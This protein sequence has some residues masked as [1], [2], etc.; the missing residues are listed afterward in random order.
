MFFVVLCCLFVSTM[1][2][3]KVVDVRIGTGPATTAAAPATATSA[4]TPI[5]YRA[6][7]GADSKQRMDEFFALIDKNCTPIAASFAQKIDQWIDSKD[8][9]KYQK[10]FTAICDVLVHPLQGIVRLF[11][12]SLR[13]AAVQRKKPLRVARIDFRR[14]SD[15]ARLFMGRVPGGLP[16]DLNLPVKFLTVA[17]VPDYL[18]V[19]SKSAMDECIAMLSKDGTFAIWQCFHKQAFTKWDAFMLPSQTASTPTEE[20]VRMCTHCRATDKPTTWCKCMRVAY[21]S[22]T[23]R[24]ACAEEHNARCVPVDEGKV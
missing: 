15:L 4:N 13:E 19:G 6:T 10:Q 16:F 11:G 17:E 18:P 2:R 7:D 23:C 20:V 5:S 8:D 9:A 14:V 1:L 3:F 12:Q 24:D 22:D 21:C